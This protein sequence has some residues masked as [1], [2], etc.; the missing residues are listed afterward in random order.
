M[1]IELGKSLG[2]VEGELVVGVIVGMEPGT[3]LGTE[4]REFVG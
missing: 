1:G 4:V 3:S 2:T